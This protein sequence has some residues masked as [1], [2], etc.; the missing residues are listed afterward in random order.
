[1]SVNYGPQTNRPPGT[2]HI[3]GYLTDEDIQGIASV[4]F[5]LVESREDYLARVYDNNSSDG[6]SK[7]NSSKKSGAELALTWIDICLTYLNVLKLLSD[8]RTFVNG[9]QH[10]LLVELYCYV[11]FILNY[12]LKGMNLCES[13]AQMVDNLKSMAANFM[14]T[15]S[16]RKDLTA[17]GH[18]CDDIIDPTEQADTPASF[19]PTSSSREVTKDDELSSINAIPPSQLTGIPSHHLLLLDI[20]TPDS[21]FASNI[22]KNLHYSVINLDPS[23][24]MKASTLDDILHILQQSNIDSYRR[25]TN[26]NNDKCIAYYS[27]NRQSGP[28]EQKVDTLIKEYLSNDSTGVYWLKGGSGLLEEELNKRSSL[29]A[30]RRPPTPEMHDTHDPR[31]SVA[32]FQAPSV[33]NLNQIPQPQAQQYPTANQPYGRPIAPLPRN[34]TQTQQIPITPMVRLF[35]YGSTCYMNSMMQCLYTIS[36]FR[37]L[38][39]NSHKFEQILHTNKDSLTLSFNH[40]FLNFYRAGGYYIVK[41][42]QFVSMCSHLKPD[43]NIPYEQQD[44]SQF[45]YFV[46]GR[47]HSEMKIQDTPSNRQ[48]F[49]TGDPETDPFASYSARQEYKNWHKSLIDHEGVSPINGLF[50]IQQETCLNCG[51]C[52]FKSYNYDYCS[53]LHLNLTGQE[54]SLNE[55]IMKNLKVEELS[56]RLGNAWNCPNCAKMTRRLQQLENK[57]YEMVDSEA[58]GKNSSSRKRSF[59]KLKKDKNRSKSESPTKTILNLDKLDDTE[60]SEYTKITTDLMKPNVSYK[61]MA[62]IK[63]PKVLVIYLAKFDQNQQK[64]NDIHLQFPKGLKFKLYRDG[65][66]V[67]YHYELK[68]WIDHLGSS[69]SSGHYTAVVSRGTEWYY[70]DDENLSKMKYDQVR[71]IKDSDAYVLFYSLSED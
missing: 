29:K 56:E 25:L 40:L 67:N 64:I 51:R 14:E 58:N 54:R 59:F 4:Q 12:V 47:L 37:N 68:S 50:Q 71:E 21:F 1:M 55:L 33:P 48:R 63:L 38:L 3:M 35:N 60:R 70:C 42:G 15:D 18:I 62:F 44:T 28:I 9:T 11:Y 2:K 5:D 7:S 52:G 32:S 39:I 24:V 19:Y 46:M 57:C 6:E 30:R 22:S 10:E 41:P 69:I 53:M 23:M 49:H 43:L 16:Y 13:D 61:S 26:M 17:A 8:K 27:S 31:S 66:E 34:T 45:L 20:R 36:S 65:S